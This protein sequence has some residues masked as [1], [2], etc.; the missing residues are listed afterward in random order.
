MKRTVIAVIFIILIPC[1][2]HAARVTQEQAA[3]VAR[4]FYA[5]RACLTGT[6]AYSQILTGEVTPVTGA[7]GE[8]L[9]YI[10]DIQSPGG[11]VIV[12]GMDNIVP[13]LAYAFSGSFSPG[14][15]NVSAWMQHYEM[16]ITES[17][18]QLTEPREGVREQWMRLSQPGSSL[19]LDMHNS[20]SVE[21]LLVSKWNQDSY[22]NGQCPSD[23][24]GP[25]GHCYAGCVATAM[26]QLMYYYRFPHQG[27]GSYTYVHPDYGTLSA[28]FGATTYDWNG[29]PSALHKPNLPVATLLYHL[30][31]SVDMDYGPDGSGMW[32]HKAA[33]SLRTYFRYGP[34]TQYYFRDS[35]SLDWDSIL[36]ANLD[37]RKPLYYAGWA[38]VQSTSG[39]AFVC[40]GYQ[41]PDYFHFNWGWGGSSDGYFYIDSLTPGGSNFNFAQ[42]VIPMFPDTTL[43]NYP[44]YCNGST[45]LTALRG[46]VEDGSGWEP[47]LPNSSCR[48]LIQP[49]DPE[50]DSIAGVRLT[51]TRMDLEADHDSVFIYEGDTVTA[52]LI[53]AFSGNELPSV[54]VAESDKVLIVFHSDASG[55]LDGWEADYEPVFPVYCSGTT[56]LTDFSGTVDDGSGNRNYNNSTFCR[57]KIQPSNAVSVTLA[58]TS[59]NLADT[60]DKLKIYD[61]SNLQL[62]A[63]LTGSE[64]PSPV[65]SPSGKILLVFNTG[66]SQN[67]DGW[68]G[69]YTGSLVGIESEAAADNEWQVYP[70]PVK[71]ILH[72]TGTSAESGKATL[73]LIRSDGSVA[74]EQDAALVEGKNSW[75]LNVENLPESLYL[76]RI[77]LKNRQISRKILIE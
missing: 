51:F 63:S 37:Q 23:P 75:M 5:E 77:A 60:M 10:V 40:D 73:R 17:A 58:F 67:S 45:V 7:T 20:S 36:V 76:L 72:I 15:C 53:G 46:S 66:G 12:S 55:N 41:S 32:N 50:Y 61:Q 68:E 44:D 11:F 65:T 54:I 52:P 70:V 13:V 43:N 8:I 42:E 47:Y 6:D 3:I 62:L 56:L 49:Q 14:Y 26:G 34:E 57:W 69:Y 71:G 25:D 29:M 35:T 16:E 22:Y 4:N 28:D 59:F 21:P 31:V 19:L 2:I 33:Y 9:Y 39:H 48:W 30:G 24:A 18:V 64:L 74:L 27:Q 1:I 38:A